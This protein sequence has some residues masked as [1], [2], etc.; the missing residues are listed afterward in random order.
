MWVISAPILL[1]RGLMLAWSL[2]LAYALL[3]W[4]GWAWECFSAGGLW[5]PL[6]WRKR[7]TGDA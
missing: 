4:L 5:R 6:R 3:K 7:S 1:Y 2:W